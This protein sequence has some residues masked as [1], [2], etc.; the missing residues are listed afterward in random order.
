[1]LRRELSELRL[2]GEQ[3]R[4]YLEHYLS[5]GFGLQQ[6]HYV[7]WRQIVQYLGSERICQLA[8]VT[9]DA[10][11]LG[12]KLLTWANSDDASVEKPDFAVVS[13]AV[14]ARRRDAHLSPSS[15]TAALTARS[16]GVRRCHAHVR[17]VVYAVPRCAGACVAAIA[18]A[19]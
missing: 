3:P 5:S 2:S 17:Q 1:M 18:Q 6:T 8:A 4:A 15:R 19:R 16:A 12:S 7:L 9:T 11:R 14:K 13:N 10:R